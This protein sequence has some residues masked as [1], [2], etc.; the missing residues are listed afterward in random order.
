M[1]IVPKTNRRL[2]LGTLALFGV[3]GGARAADE[4]VLHNQIVRP[5]TTTQMVVG[6]NLEQ[7]YVSF[8][9]DLVL[10]EGLSVPANSEG[11]PD[12]Q[13]M[14]GWARDHVFDCSYLS[15]N[16]VR[17]ACFTFTNAAL[18]SSSGPLLHVK[19]AAASDFA[20]DATLSL[21]N[22]RFATSKAKETKCETV[23]AKVITV[24]QKSL[25]LQL[26]NNWNWVSQNT[27]NTRDL[28]VFISP[29]GELLQRL[30]SDTQ[31]L[32]RDSKYGIVGNLTGLEPQKGYRMQLSAE[33]DYAS[34]E[35]AWCFSDDYPLT[36]HKGWN[37]I[38]YLPFSAMTVT[39]AMANLKASENDRIVGQEKFADYKDGQWT[40]TLTVMK[41][42]TAYQ[43]KS[44]A[45]VTFCYPTS[46]PAVE[47]VAESRLKTAAPWSCD[48]HLYADVMTMIVQTDIVDSEGMPLL[49]AAFCGDECR[50]ISQAVQNMQ[51][52]TVHGTVAA[53]ETIH[54]VAYDA[55]T[56]SQYLMDGQ[57]VFDG[58]AYGQISEPLMLHVAT[59]V[60]TAIKG[61]VKPVVS[62]SVS[63]NRLY[64]SG[65]IAAVS[66]FSANG[67]ILRRLDAVPQ[68][69]V[70]LSSYP[71]G[72]YAVAL[73]MTDGSTIVR[74]FLR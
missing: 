68:N 43:Y 34:P 3:L 16:V 70:D 62:M 24:P 66:L 15:A 59:D 63:G 6:V 48:A 23:A 7:D 19:L 49:V 17:V 54:F 29:V 53:G 69:G 64:L 61:L 13:L 73:T 9:M 5:G 52:L 26:A 40:G 25:Q 4:V 11:L 60:A 33:Q 32:V 1:K 8:Q 14:D 36:L 35:G 67:M 12:V 55:E 44:G 65:Q 74:K 2:F 38:G 28:S 71:S 22:V 57:M 42:G 27:E 41:P 10:P 39:D 21:E 58:G 56:G 72:V 47:P 45:D 51:F 37:W 46:Y 50:G 31:E 30:L 18:A 20:G